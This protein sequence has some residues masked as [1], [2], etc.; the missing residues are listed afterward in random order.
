MSRIQNTLSHLSEQGKKA[1]VP[2]FVAGDPNPAI[3]V[4]M[5]HKQV[6]AG[7]D[8]IELGIAFSDPMAEGPTIQRA[9][10]RALE[11][12]ISLRDTLSLV[13]E[14]RQQDKSTPVVLMGY[15]N[16]IEVIG[17][18][19]F[20]LEAQ[21]AG[22]D[23]VLVVDLPPE[24]AGDFQVILKQHDI[25][26]I[27]LIAPTTAQSRI[28]QIVS[29]ATGYLYYVSLKGVTGAGHLDVESVKSKLS[30]I[31]SVTDLPIC[32]GFGIKDEKSAKQI[33]QLAD[34]AVVGSA[35]VDRMSAASSPEQALDDVYDF[36]SGIRQ[37]MD[38][39]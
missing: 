1:L 39:K 4:D 3:T 38:T 16:P 6:S 31:R 10:E 21:A 12:N 8:I 29:L 11:H 35:I 17:Y 23:G 24:E 7:A 32:V 27:F 26:I 18:E 15:A 22:V 13:A 19:T 14:F 34:G 30:D 28:E 2:Y 5:M 9:H 36:L 20:A 37:A 33:S 25:D